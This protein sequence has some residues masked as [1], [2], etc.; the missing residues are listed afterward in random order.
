[1]LFH[2]KFTALKKETGELKLS[3]AIAKIMTEQELVNY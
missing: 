1:L 2:K 3:K